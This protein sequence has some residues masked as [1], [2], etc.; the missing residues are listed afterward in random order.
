MSSPSLGFLHGFQP[1]RFAERVVD[2]PPF[3][4]GRRCSTDSSPASSPVRP[5]VFGADR[6]D[7]L[8][9]HLAL[10]VGA[11][12]V[13]QSRRSL[14]ASSRSIRAAVGRSTLWAT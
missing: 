4:V 6:A 1:D 5:C 13:G 12:A 8:R 3:A 14:P 2:D 10:R 9:R 11:A 7:H